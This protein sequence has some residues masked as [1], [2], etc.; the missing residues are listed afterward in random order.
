MADLIRNIHIKALFVIFHSETLFSIEELFP[1]NL[2][3]TYIVKIMIPRDIRRRSLL[4]KMLLT[5]KCFTNRTK[6]IFNFPC[7]TKITPH[8][9]LVYDAVYVKFM[10]NCST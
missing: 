7:K 4:V 6:E 8:S 9:A 10:V 2:N 5:K 3:L 1:T